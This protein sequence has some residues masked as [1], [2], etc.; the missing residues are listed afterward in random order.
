MSLHKSVKS[1][2]ENEIL[3]DM[4]L[5]KGFVLR[6]VCGERVIVGEGLENVDFSK[7]L[8]INET[9][10]WIWKKASELG[11]FTAEQLA[12]AL[13]QEYNVEPAQAV[14]DVSELLGQWTELGIA[15]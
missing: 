3:K 4:R 2:A 12:E 15:E 11:D 9:A 8:S 13:C 6:E 1:D 10:A 5:K 14:A 7:L